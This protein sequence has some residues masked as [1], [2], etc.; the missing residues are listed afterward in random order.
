MRWTLVHQTDDVVRQ[1]AG[2]ASID[3]TMKYIHQ[4]DDQLNKAVAQLDI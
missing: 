3:T 4:T 2:H 1:L